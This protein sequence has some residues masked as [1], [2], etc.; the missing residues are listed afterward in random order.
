MNGQRSQLPLAAAVAAL[1][2]AMTAGVPGAQ[3]NAWTTSENTLVLRQAAGYWSSN[4][5]FASDLDRELFFPQRQPPSP[6]TGERIPFD[7]VTG[8]RFRIF[9]MAT[10]LAYGINQWLDVAATLPVLHADFDIDIRPGDPQAATDVVD[11]RTGIGDLLL[12]SKARIFKRGRFI[13]ASSLELKL[14]TGRFEPAVWQT[15]L[16]EGQTDVAGFIH[17]GVSLHPYGYFAAA[18]GWK[19]RFERSSNTRK[20]GDEA[21]AN[22]ELGLALPKGFLAKAAIDALLGQEGRI[23]QFGTPLPRRR[24]VSVWG[25]LI[26]RASK[27]LT[28]DASVRWLI[29]GEDFPTGIPV[30]A[31]VTYSASLARAPE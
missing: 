22:A 19:R 13:A 14:P 15:P 1:L 21:H 30:F 24:L 3:A 31:G 17:L 18:T 29:A 5:K 9:S 2:A 7:P 23:R 27:T 12:S 26:W 6:Q 28:L 10:S 8:G 11:A 25:S 16:T 4:R 20:P